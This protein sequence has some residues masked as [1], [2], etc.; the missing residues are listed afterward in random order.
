MFHQLRDST[1]YTQDCE[2]NSLLGPLFRRA[3][4]SEINNIDGMVNVCF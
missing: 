2:M 1:I 4:I 3:G